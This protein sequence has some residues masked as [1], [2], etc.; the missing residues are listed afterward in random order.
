[1][2]YAFIVY[3]Y[4]DAIERAD[5]SRQEWRKIGQQLGDGVLQV[6]LGH[7]GPRA[8]LDKAID[9]ASTAARLHPSAPRVHEELESLRQE[10][11]QRRVSSAPVANMI[12]GIEYC[13]E[14]HSTDSRLY[15]WLGNCLRPLHKLDAE[16]LDTVARL[17]K[18]ERE[19]RALEEAGGG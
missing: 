8:E 10:R 16:D 6:C 9:I 2:G 13:D 11:V 1:M 12:N 17:V 3:V 4:R 19:R 15:L 5:H 7:T 14:V 18:D